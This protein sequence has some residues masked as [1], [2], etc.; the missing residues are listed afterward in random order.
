MHGTITADLTVNL[1][2]RP[3]GI[4]QDVRFDV[5]HLPVIGACSN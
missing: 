3:A 4:T 1:K 5:D 2:P